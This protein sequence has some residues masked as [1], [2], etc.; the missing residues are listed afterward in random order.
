MKDYNEKKY[1]NSNKYYT[2]RKYF[3]IGKKY[4]NA[5][6]YCRARK[7]TVINRVFLYSCNAIQNANDQNVVFKTNNKIKFISKTILVRTVIFLVLL[8][9]ML[10]RGGGGGGRAKAGVSNDAV[11][12]RKL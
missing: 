2:E 3:Y 10:A 8:D 9:D 1:H 5:N 11:C 4:Y 7:C 12:A 6:K